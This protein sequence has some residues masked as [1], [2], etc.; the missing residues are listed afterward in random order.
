ML[1]GLA[2]AAAV[3]LS[4]PILRMSTLRHLGVSAL[5]L[6][7]GAFPLILYNIHTRGGTFHGN[8]VYDAARMPEK[9]RALA[10]TIRG[11]GLMG[12]LSP[13]DWQTAHPHAPR[14]WVERASVEVASF[15]GSPGQSLQLYGLLL[16]VLLI[17]LA[18]GPALR[19]LIFFVVALVVAWVQMAFTA[20]AGNA[21]HHTILLWPLPQAIMAVSFA[22]ASRRLGDAGVPAVATITAVLM[23]SGLLLINSYY[24]RIVRN[25]S[26]ISWTDA[27]YPLSDYLRKTDATEVYCMDWGFLDTLRLLSDGKLPVRVGEDPIQRPELTGDDREHLLNMVSGANH[28]FVTHEKGFEFFP[29]LTE[30]LAKFAEGVGYRKEELAQFSDS[31][32]RPTFEVFRFVG[33]APSSASWRK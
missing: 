9:V 31:K 17:P 3:T 22:A 1:S 2:V 27:V 14:G 8:A 19:A 15:A 29:G 24:A 6:C 12:Y 23:A 16:A 32:G 25:G 28:I 20:H 13:E 33:Q 30:K 5:S 26:A 11:S 10:D 18:R 4:K 7:V 21:L